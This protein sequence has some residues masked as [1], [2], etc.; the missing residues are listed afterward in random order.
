MMLA[1]VF[2]HIDRIVFVDFAGFSIQPTAGALS[3]TLVC[4]KNQTPKFAAMQ[5][6]D[7]QMQ[8]FGC[9]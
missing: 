6:S 8:L 4:P 5:V 2:K 9:C 7:L 1:R 3:G